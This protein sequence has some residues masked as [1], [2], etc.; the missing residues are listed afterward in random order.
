MYIIS[1]RYLIQS[2]WQT[3]NGLN[4]ATDVQTLYLRSSIVAKAVKIVL[5]EWTAQGAALKFD[6]ISCRTGVS[7]V[8][9]LTK[10]KKKNCPFNLYRHMLFTPLYATRGSFGPGNI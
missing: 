8:S 9:L 3:F 4:N 6:I 1:Y 2:V 7:V 5:K 10:R